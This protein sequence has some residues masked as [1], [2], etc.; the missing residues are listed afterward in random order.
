MPGV[1]LPSGSSTTPGRQRQQTFCRPREGRG[2]QK[3]G[4]GAEQLKPEEEFL[5]ANTRKWCD[6]AEAL[7]RDEAAGVSAGVRRAPECYQLSCVLHLPPGVLF[8]RCV[9]SSR[10][11]F[12][13]IL[14]PASQVPGGLSRRGAGRRPLP[15]PTLAGEVVLQFACCQKVFGRRAATEGRRLFCCNKAGS[16]FSH[17]HA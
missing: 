5:A 10:L 15:G 17:C 13:K 16:R 4:S 14:H 2:L 1:R 11:S 3:I 9:F 7:V 12:L 6:F 8:G